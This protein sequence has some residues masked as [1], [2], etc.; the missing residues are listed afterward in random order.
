[1]SDYIPNARAHSN[2]LSIVNTTP[3]IKRTATE[4][5]INANRLTKSRRIDFE[6]TG[7]DYSKCTKHEIALLLK[8]R[9]IP[10]AVAESKSAL[11]EKNKQNG[12]FSKPKEVILN[13]INQFIV[14][15]N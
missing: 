11:I 9:S 1:M 5:L 6:D 8:S 13:T 3:G 14:C 15:C 4:E 7:V 10:F 12:K 2:D